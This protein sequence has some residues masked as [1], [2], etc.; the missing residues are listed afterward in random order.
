MPDYMKNGPRK[1]NEEYNYKQAFDYFD[2][3]NNADLS[4]YDNHNGTETVD[5]KSVDD[6]ILSNADPTVLN[7]VEEE[8]QRIHHR[9]NW[10]EN[11]D[12]FV[13]PYMPI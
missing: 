4:S 2:S 7:Q 12:V 5:L 10:L 3:L 1:Y 6:I 11:D 13:N 9:Q 8:L